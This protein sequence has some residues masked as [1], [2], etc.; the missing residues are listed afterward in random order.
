MG[1]SVGLSKY[2]TYQGVAKMNE[3]KKDAQRCHRHGLQGAIFWLNRI[4]T[5]SRL[6]PQARGSHGQL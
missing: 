4:I 6:S 5:F 2:S 1:M 3:D